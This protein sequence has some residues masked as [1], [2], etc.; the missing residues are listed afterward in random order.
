MQYALIVLGIIIFTAFF[1]PIFKEV[2]NLAS[3]CGLSLSAV[4]LFVGIFYN[5]L[6]EKIKITAIVI[7]TAAVICLCLS[8]VIVLSGTKRADS[9]KMIIIL[10]C[11]VRG[12]TASVT[13]EKRVLCAV[14]FLQKN[15]NAKA[16]LSGGQGRGEKISEALC[17]KRLL[18]KNGID[19]NRLLI[20]DKSTTTYENFLFSKR[21]F[22]GEGVEDIAVATSEYHQKRARLICRRLGV[23]AYSVSS[24]TPLTLLP[25]FVLREL[26][27]LVK[28][29]MRP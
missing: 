29:F 22:E 26:F 5:I 6:N 18:V 24:K 7:I 9:Q 27:A 4:T 19:E 25:T 14:E 20:E 2:F 23:N 13:L 3:F 11:K 21:F 16:V 28:E 15:P 1:L 12:E 10:G 8:Y 17:M